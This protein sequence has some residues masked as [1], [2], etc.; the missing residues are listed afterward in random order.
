[1]TSAPTGAAR[2]G[3]IGAGEEI[4]F[5]GGRFSQAPAL[6]Q[7]LFGI[8]NFMQ[9]TAE[10]GQVII[11]AIYELV[12]LQDYAWKYSGHG[13]YINTNAPAAGQ[14]S[15]MLVDKGRYIGSTIQNLTA[16]NRINNLQRPST[17]ISAI[18]PPGAP[19]L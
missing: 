12:S 1:M 18:A 5:E 16:K 9:L 11:D 6:V 7:V 14:V 17:A 13:F 19:D 10:G 2:R 3:Y 8:F 4:S 15:R